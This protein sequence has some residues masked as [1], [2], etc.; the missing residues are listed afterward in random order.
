MSQEDRIAEVLAGLRHLRQ[1]PS[2]EAARDL[3]EDWAAQRE[4][5]NQT[6]SA[7]RAHE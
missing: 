6:D 3:L 2:P 5:Y 4:M 1:N 7:W